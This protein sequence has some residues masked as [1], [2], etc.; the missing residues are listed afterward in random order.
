LKVLPADVLRSPKEVSTFLQEEILELKKSGKKVLKVTVGVQMRGVPIL[1]AW[2]KALEAFSNETTL[3]EFYG[4]IEGELSASR[5]GRQTR[6]GKKNLRR[7]KHSQF[8]SILC[9]LADRGILTI[10]P[11]T[12]LDEVGGLTWPDT[13]SMWSKNSASSGTGGR[14]AREISA[15]WVKPNLEKL[16]KETGSQTSW[17]EERTVTLRRKGE[18]VGSVIVEGLASKPIHLIAEPP[19]KRAAR[20]EKRKCNRIAS[21]SEKSDESRSRAA[22]DGYQTREE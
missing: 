15:V 18:G 3:K 12:F 19:S 7:R 10:R 4:Y 5:T 21:P 22:D 20:E 11:S 8:L 13:D 1:P 2:R 6:I 17:T 9:R 14:W 16:R